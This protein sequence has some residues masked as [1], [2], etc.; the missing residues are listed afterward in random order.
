MEDRPVHSPLLSQC[1]LGTWAP[2]Q[3]MCP[4]RDGVG[5]R[6]YLQSRQYSAGGA[7][8]SAHKELAQVLEG[9]QGALVREGRGWGGR[10][11]MGTGERVA[12]SSDGVP[13]LLPQKQASG[14]AW[15]TGPGGRGLGCPHPGDLSQHR[16]FPEGARFLRV[17]HSQAGEGPPGPGRGLR[18]RAGRGTCRHTPS[19][20][21]TPA[22]TGPQQVAAP[23]PS[24]GRCPPSLSQA[25]A[26]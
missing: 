23:A 19:G 24:P 26:W 12:E 4:L 21:P 1:R 10:V 2:C 9:A 7:C 13:A 8:V 6:R 18:L 14:A 5:G 11:T 3:G 25:L 22:L 15:S 20:E 17:S 16:P